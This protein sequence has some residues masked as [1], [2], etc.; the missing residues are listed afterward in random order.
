MYG[1]ASG[2]ESSCDMDMGQYIEEVDK[3]NMGLV[4]YHSGID[5]G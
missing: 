5:K 3:G 4:A 2:Q 1:Q